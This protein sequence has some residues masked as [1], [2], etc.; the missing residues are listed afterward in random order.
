MDLNGSFRQQSGSLPPIGIGIGIGIE[1]L[2]TCA[3]PGKQPCRRY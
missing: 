3:K 1:F 2:L